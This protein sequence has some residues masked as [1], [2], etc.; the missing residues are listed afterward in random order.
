MELPIFKKKE[1][2]YSRRKK[3]LIIVLSVFLALAIWILYVLNGLRAFVP[4]YPFLS[5]LPFQSKNY[6]V[7]F[8]N[9]AELRPGGGFMT[10]YGI[11]R[12]V[13]G[14]PVAFEVNDIFSLSDGETEYI[15]PP[16][17]MGEL[18]KSP[19]YK[20]WAF[21][22]SNWYADFEQNAE[23]MIWF[24]NR[25]FPGDNID[26]VFAVNY[27]VIEELL[28]IIGEV[29]VNDQVF[30]RANLFTR[31]EYAVSNIDRHNVED[32]K[33]RKDI[34][35][36]LYSKI[37]QAVLLS[38]VKYE[39]VSTLID[40]KLKDKSIQLYFKDAILAN[41]AYRK[42]WD[43]EIHPKGKSDFL[44][45]VEA[46]LAGMKSDRYLQREIYYTVDIDGKKDELGQRRAKATV[47]VHMT[48]TGDYNEPLSYTYS[49]FLRLLLPPESTLLKSENLMRTEESGLLSAGQK[50]EVKPGEEQT[51]TWEYILPPET[52]KN[53]AYALHIHKQSGTDDIYHVTIHAPPDFVLSGKDWDLRDNIAMYRG[54][55]T[56]DL[57]LSLVIEEDKIPPRITFQIFKDL[58]TVEIHFNDTVNRTECEKKE[59][60][61]I[62]DSNAKNGQT[63]TITITNVSCGDKGLTMTLRGVTVQPEEF[64]K[65]RVKNLQDTYGNVI[66]PN[67]KEITIVQRINP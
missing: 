4:Y 40:Q 9:E 57:D 62:Y 41:V 17:P 30:N 19:F 31:L 20:G 39:F 51:Y 33:R 64:Y 11:L 56:K 3:V 5:G 53:N 32:L 43:G 54:F 23:K 18:L 35:K 12:F 38:P 13:S 44:A 25:K 67:P 14:V 61:E 45:V 49:G 24:Y 63:D 50:V 42:G 16:Y 60:Y 22:D 59:N 1:K 52:V 26:G 58:S 27:G 48:H 47:S 2:E 34:L 8:Q 65:L 10:A 55:L 37:L 15:E 28:G 66:T 21:Q 6:L 36:S 29:K 46:N 7:V